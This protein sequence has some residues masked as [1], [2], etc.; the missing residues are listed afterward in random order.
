M[1]RFAAWLARNADAAVALLLA[2]FVGALGLSPALGDKQS[3]VVA[4]ATLVVLGLLATAILRD[5]YRRAPVEEEVRDT[6][7]GAS[8]VLDAL[9][10]RLSRMEELENLVVRTRQALDES[11]VVQVL[12]G[13]EVAPT[14][15]KARRTT[16]R[17]IYK[18]GT[19][20]YIR[21]VTLPE[22]VG[23]ARRDRRA[24]LVRLEILDPTDEE[25]CDTYARFRRSALDE[26]DSSG[27]LW[28]LERTRKESFATILAACWHRQRFR[29]LDIDIGLS[30]AMTTFRWDLSSSCVVI[31]REDPSAPAMMVDR[32]KFYYDWCT[33]EL[34][35]SLDQARRVPIEQ[36]RAAP[37][38]DEPTV[39]EVRKLFDVLNLGLPRS[40]TDRD[41]GDIA[42]KALQAKNPYE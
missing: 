7:R 23:F 35:A 12:N 9:P 28:T 18:G 1:V 10:E 20:T 41:V 29:L 6:L 33:T 11:S 15:A 24:L 40:F 19:G 17:W 25:V 42:R 37:L 14:L 34:L 5:R 39:E 26:T 16:D 38:G 30:S 21:A 32:G 27:E 22:C 2:V 8:R 31:T 13:A 36:A 3:E 4:S